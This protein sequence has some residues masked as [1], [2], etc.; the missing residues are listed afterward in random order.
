MVLTTYTSL[1]ST[2]IPIDLLHSNDQKKVLLLIIV[3]ITNINDEGNHSL[4][5]F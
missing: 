3:N 1:V 2:T 5:F 4:Y